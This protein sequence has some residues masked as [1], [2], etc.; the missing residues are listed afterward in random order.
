MSQLWIITYASGVVQEEYGASEQD[1]RD[2][3]ARCYKERGAIKSIVEHQFEAQDDECAACF[4]ISDDEF[5]GEC[6]SC[7]RLDHRVA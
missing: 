6:C 2:F 4:D 3:V 7:G 1:V 5:F